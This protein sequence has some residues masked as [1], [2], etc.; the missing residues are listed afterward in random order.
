MPASSATTTRHLSISGRVQGVGYR[1][2]M[3]QQ[4]DDL[5]LSG[6]VRN[7]HDGSVETVLCGQ[8]AAVQA[9]FDWAHQGPAMARVDAVPVSDATQ[10]DIEPLKGFEQRETV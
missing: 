5:G 4:A 3:A 1:W 9:L 2:A 10:H 8:P 7:R 6:W